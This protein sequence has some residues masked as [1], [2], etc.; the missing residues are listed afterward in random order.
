MGES[1]GESRPEVIRPPEAACCPGC[2][3]AVGDEWLS[4]RKDPDNRGARLEEFFQVIQ[5]ETRRGQRGVGL[6]GTFKGFSRATRDDS[7]RACRDPGI[8]ESSFI[9]RPCWLTFSS[10]DMKQNPEKYA[11]RPSDCVL[12]KVISVPSDA[13]EG[14]G[15]R[16][17]ARLAEN[18]EAH[19]STLALC[20]DATSPSR[21]ALKAARSDAKGDRGLEATSHTQRIAPRPRRCS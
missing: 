4:Y 3:G 16:D 18:L 10:P 19:R 14:R 13:A 2:G 8:S 7:A 20:Q 12:H 15:A 1:P 17:Q 9:G 5:W 6:A 11:K 21:P